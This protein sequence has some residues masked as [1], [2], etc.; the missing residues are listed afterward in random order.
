MPLKDKADLWVSRALREP[1]KGLTWPS[2]GLGHL[3]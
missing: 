3:M 1:R 2:V